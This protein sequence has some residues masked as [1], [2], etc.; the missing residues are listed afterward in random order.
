MNLKKVLVILVIGY[1]VV[2]GW[3]IGTPYVK[4]VMF[5][6]DLDTIARTL[7]VDGTVQ[8]ARNQVKNAVIY[9][10]IPAAEEGFTILKDEKTR[11]VVVEAKYTVSVTTPFGFYTHVWNFAPRAEKGLQR[12]PRPAE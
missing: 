12:I 9:N 11:Q 8:K 3:R 5:Q 2:S 10:G 1:L 4:N 7:S 6:N